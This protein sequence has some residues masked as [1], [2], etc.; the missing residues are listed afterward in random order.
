MPSSDLTARMYFDQGQT[1]F[2]RGDYSAAEDY[3]KKA[4]EKDPQ[5]HEAH[6]YLAESFEKQG[7]SHRARTAWERLSRITRDAAELAEIKK[8]IEAL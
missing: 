6:R 2:G 4:V 5:Y 1:A 8:R 3:F 7:F